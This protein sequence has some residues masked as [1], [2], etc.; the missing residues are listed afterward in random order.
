MKDWFP[1]D[2]RRFEQI[3]V[4]TQQLLTS[5]GFRR[6]DSPLL[7]KTDLFLRKFGG[8]VA[9][10]LY[11]FT[12]PGG[13]K[14][15]LRPE[16]TSSVIRMLAKENLELGIPLRVQYSGPV[17]RYEF[18]GSDHD[19]QSIQVGGELIGDRSNFA[20]SEILNIACQAI[21]THVSKP[22]LSGIQLYLNHIGVVT[23]LLEQFAIPERDIDLILG[24]FGKL[25]D[26]TKGKVFLQELGQNLGFFGSPTL[27]N[28][29]LVDPVSPEK[30]DLPTLSKRLANLENESGLGGRSADEIITRLKKKQESFDSNLSSR[31]EM[32]LK[33]AS[34]LAQLKGHP[35]K[36]IASAKLLSG[37]FN[38]DVSCLSEIEDL[39]RNLSLYRLDE[40]ITIS[41]DLGLTMG[42]AYYSGIVFEIQS[43][44]NPSSLP[45][46]RGGRYDRLVKALGGKE[47]IPA[48][49]FAINLDRLASILPE[50]Y[51]MVDTNH[52]P[53]RVLIIPEG[54]QSYQQ[55][56]KLAEEF[57][58]K[59]KITEIASTNLDRNS[60]ETVAAESGIQTLIWVNDDGT[61]KY[62]T[63][64]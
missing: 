59:G 43:P 3:T 57:R 50:D 2:L 55:S 46:A 47:Q 38:L 34:E 12:E 33:F 26:A 21:L 13:H 29:F 58:N 63:I 48:L 20:D 39:L 8:K 25:K 4:K 32:A 27:K 24:N 1:L 28:D 16:F 60:L 35:S 9:P 31:L 52:P 23:H 41:L 14:V 5:H 51:P 36:T 64:G 17:F 56:L 30:N 61:N 11:T 7:E 53:D 19:L 15:S 40:S 54:F 45:L 37:Q 49:G 44:S 10:H 22:N 42:T 62:I 6:I 18:E